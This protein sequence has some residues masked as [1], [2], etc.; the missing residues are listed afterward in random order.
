M[1]V[2]RSLRV[3]PLRPAPALG[4]PDGPA[5]AVGAIVPV[6]LVQ[7]TAPHFSAGLVL[8][9]A[10]GFRQTLLV[11]EAAPILR[12]MV[13]WTESRVTGHCA[14]KGWTIQAGGQK[15]P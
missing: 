11:S 9:P 1:G 8:V 14:R 12:Y 7:I 6:K 5:A 4:A 3:S 2:G 15:P 13:G 10:P